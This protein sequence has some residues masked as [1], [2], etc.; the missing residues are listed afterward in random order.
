MV[1][2]LLIGCAS[3]VLAPTPSTPAVAP[4]APERPAAQQIVP[5]DRERSLAA[6]LE[7]DVNE[8]SV[9]IGERNPA[10]KW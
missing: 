2:P 4:A 5:T 1:A 10:R 3:A 8:L 9:S 7:R 6:E